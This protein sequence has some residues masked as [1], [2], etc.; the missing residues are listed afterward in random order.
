MDLKRADKAT[1]ILGFAVP[2][3][4]VIGFFIRPKGYVMN[5]S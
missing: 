2:F 4:D 1:K 3:M 5:G